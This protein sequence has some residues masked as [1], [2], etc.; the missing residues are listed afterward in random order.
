MSTTLLLFYGVFLA[1]IFLA[2]IYFPMKIRKR[3]LYVLKNYPPKDYPKLYPK[4]SDFYAEKAARNGLKAYKY[5]NLAIAGIG[6]GI[7]GWGL[8]S[9]Y[10]PSPLGGDEI[11]V[12]FY[13]ILQASPLFY[14]ELK[15]Y[16]Q[17]KRMRQT[18]LGGAR[19][20]EL[21]PR[22]LFDFI[23]PFL[24]AL[25]VILFIG[26]VAFYLYSTGF[27][28]HWEA[29]VYGTLG[30]ITGMN[31]LFIALIAKY[32][33]GKKLNPY[34]AYADRLKQIETIVK[35][36]VFASIAAS[37][38]LTIFNLADEFGFE[39]YD[40]VL[41]S[42]YLQIALFLGLGTEFRKIKLETVDFEVY[43]K[44]KPVSPV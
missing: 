31:L 42:V 44:D 21:N 43:K 3:I 38:F 40:P 33:F 37:I 13:F 11:F 26:W 18:N 30:A 41:T 6:L 24:V 36:S 7:L 25:A 32:M 29:D 4:P 14:L 2:S 12:M 22:K 27:D 1:Q 39:L 23:S 15:G 9:G 10:T 16:K 28:A 5:I 35:T 34:Q 19:K 8:I 20:A 17:Y